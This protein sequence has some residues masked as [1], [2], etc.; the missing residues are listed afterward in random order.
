MKNR[1]N[2]IF[3]IALIGIGLLLFL[4]IIDDITSKEIFTGRTINC[5]DRDGNIFINESC[6][7]RIE[8][9]R[10]GITYPKCSKVQGVIK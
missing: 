9:G 4:G 8:C 1:G 2:I 7:E 10:L 6:K 5:V 3:M